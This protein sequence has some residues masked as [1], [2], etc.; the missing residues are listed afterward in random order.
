MYENT[1]QPTLVKNES[2]NATKD[3]I[4]MLRNEEKIFK[5]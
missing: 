5:L 3:K 4:L 1:R 2:G